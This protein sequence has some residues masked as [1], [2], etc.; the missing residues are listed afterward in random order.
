L[1]PNQ[2]R[3]GLCGEIL[4]GK[5][6]RV[7]VKILTENAKIVKAEMVGYLLMQM[8][9]LRIIPEHGNDLI[10][11]H[12]PILTDIGVGSPHIDPLIASKESITADSGIRFSSR[13][14]NRLVSGFRFMGAEMSINPFTIKLEDEIL[15][16]T[17][18]NDQYDNNRNRSDQRNLD[19]LR[20]IPSSTSIC[21]QPSITRASLRAKQN[22]C[23]PA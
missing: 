17:P 6:A 3:L 13:S 1:D 23:I 16:L 5:P 15:E 9:N 10:P 19:R 21:T 14:R 8:K 20:H 12:H 4:P 2:Q 22:R 18:K 11:A 7:D